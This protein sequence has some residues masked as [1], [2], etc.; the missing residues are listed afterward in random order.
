MSLSVSGSP[1]DDRPPMVAAMQWVSQITAISMEMVVLAVLG[2]W[3]D[4]MWGTDPWLLVSGALIGF[5][6]GMMHLF[7]IVK[8]KTNHQQKHGNKSESIRNSD[9]RK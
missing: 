9:T 1:K 3:L 2:Y 7:Q 6:V 5:A 8:Q 4:S